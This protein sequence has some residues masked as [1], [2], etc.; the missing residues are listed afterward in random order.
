MVA[1]PTYPDPVDHCR[2]CGWWLTCVARREADDHLSLVAGM[3]RTATKRLVSA[4]IPT[5]ATLG[6][7]APWLPIPDLTP[8]TFDR[9]RGQAAIQLAGRERDELIYELLPPVEEQPFHGLRALP[10]P[11]ALDVFF[12]IEADPWI[13]DAG[14][15]YLLGWSEVVDG[16]DRYHALW[17]HD[18]DSEKAAFEAFVDEVIDRLDR[19]PAM[20][21]YHYA[22]YEKTALRRLMTRYATREDAIDRILRAGVLVD[23]YQVVRQGLRAS[24]D[25]YSIKRIERFYLAQR[26]GPITR[27][28]FSVVEYERWLGDHDPQHLTDL[29]DYNRDDCVS[30]R[31]LRDWLEKRR[32]EAELRFHETFDRPPIGTG[33]PNEA[34]VAASEVTLARI[35]ALTEGATVD[36]AARSTDEAGRWLLAAL[37]DWHRR[38]SRQAWWDYFRLRELPLDDLVGESEPLGGLAFDRIVGQEKQSDILRLTFPPQ[39]HKVSRGATGWEDETGRGVTIHAVDDEHGELLI[40]RG[41]TVDAPPPRALLKGGPLD[42]RAMRE[43]LGRLADSVIAGGIDGDGPYRAVRDLLLRRSPRIAG[44]ADGGALVEPGETVLQAAR[45]IA[46]GLPE[47]ETVLAIQGPPG[48]G[49]TYTGGRMIVELVRAGRRVGISA[50]AHKAITNLLRETVEAARE[51]GVP[52]RALQR[53]DGGEA[54]DELAEV[55]EATN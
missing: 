28:G 27:A 46:V 37:L 18:R 31:G 6:D 10:A 3:T 40:R 42:G 29:A 16:V 7:T 4:G 2:V 52:L 44:R 33:L 43:A 39:D 20:H 14:L 35:A 1:A 55:A 49:K 34:Q 25:S 30:T 21:V 24:V 12:D 15:E 50:Q 54:A 19:D 47:A 32:S 26:E 38:D 36:P 22:A 8:T 51:A 11:S 48:T 13:G 45:R 23:L 17:A 41:K 5:L 53:I 9:L